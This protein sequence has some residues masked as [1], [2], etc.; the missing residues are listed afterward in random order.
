MSGVDVRRRRT[1][2]G[3][4]VLERRPSL[5]V[6]VLADT[7]I[8]GHIV[9]HR[10]TD[11]FDD[12]EREPHAILER[13]TV[14]V[15]ALIGERREERARQ[16]AVRTMDEHHVE[17][18]VAKA[19]S[20]IGEL[21]NHLGHA[22]FRYLLELVGIHV[23]R[24]PRHP[25]LAALEGIGL[26]DAPGMKNLAREGGTVPMHFLDQAMEPGN[27]GVT[28]HGQAAEEVTRTTLVDR[29]CADGHH[30]HATAGLRTEEL[31]ERLGNLSVDNASMSRD[32]R[33]ENQAVLEL[34][35]AYAHR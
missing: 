21:L 23:G 4:D 9:S 15:S 25:S 28:A 27:I 16:V 22:F 19:N 5:D 18:C 6:F 24:Q 33:R 10:L 14:L 32:D 17:P 30:A 2:E 8:D 29:R 11:G 3:N 13:T 34:Q 20:R 31:H 26:R 35:I 12:L 7:E 1:Q